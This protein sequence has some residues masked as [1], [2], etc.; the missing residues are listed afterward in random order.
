M[1]SVATHRLCKDKS[2][3]TKSLMLKEKLNACRC[4]AANLVSLACL[5]DVELTKKKK[6]LN[7]TLLSKVISKGR[8]QIQVVQKRLRSGMKKSLKPILAPRTR[9]AKP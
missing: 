3:T 2:K 1:K 5:S 4:R 9:R 6:K 8:A 7:Q